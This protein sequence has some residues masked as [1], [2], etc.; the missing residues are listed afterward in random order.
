M[1]ARG[2]RGATRSRPVTADRG[3]SAGQPPQRNCAELSGDLEACERLAQSDRR[4]I[5]AR[6]NSCLPPRLG[7]TPDLFARYA[8]PGSAVKRVEGATYDVLAAADCAIVASGTATVE[9]ALLGTPM[10][11]VYRVSA[12]SA[13]ILRRMVRSPFIAMVNLIADGGSCRN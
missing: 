5:A 9:A 6:F 12:A 11:V 1:H 10:V 13:F 2:I 7:S 8:R 4:K 3:A